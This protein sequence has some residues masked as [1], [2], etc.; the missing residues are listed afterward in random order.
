MVRAGAISNGFSGR[1]F[2]FYFCFAAAAGGREAAFWRSRRDKK[3]AVSA[4]VRES[5]KDSEHAAAAKEKE[6][7]ARD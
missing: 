6:R 3:R 5:D 7:E 1:V 2:S 4:L